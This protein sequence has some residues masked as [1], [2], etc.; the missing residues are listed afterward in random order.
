MAEEP[1]FGVWATL[2]MESFPGCPPGPFERAARRLS[3][4]RRAKT[5]SLMRCLR[6]ERFFAGLP[7]GQFLLE[8]GPAC[9]VALA[10]LGD[11]GHVDGR[12]R[13]GRPAAA[14]LLIALAVSAFFAARLLNRKRLD[15]LAEPSEVASFVLAVAGVLVAPF[16]KIV[17]WV[18]G[19]QPLMPEEIAS[20]RD[21]LHATLTLRCS[22]ST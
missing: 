6:A 5:A 15:W 20:A 17:R 19:P 16:G 9:A 12:D 8:V 2:A 11:R 18:R 1:V 3:A 10:D 4:W 14:V 21:R 13:H 22:M 7:L